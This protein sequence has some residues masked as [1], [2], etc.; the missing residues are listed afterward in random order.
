VTCDLPV[1]VIVCTRNRAH[2]LPDCLKSLSLQNCE[3]PF[4]VLVVDNGS[5]D[6]TPAVIQEWCLKDKRFRTTLEP[7]VGLSAAKNTG[8]RLARGQL[9]LF[10]DDDV[11][12]D[13]GWVRAYVTFFARGREDSI[14]AGGPIFPVP[15]DLED[16]PKWF[17]SCALADL[18]LLDYRDERPLGRREYVWGANMGIPACTFSRLGSWDEDV[19]RRG[20]A[21]GTFEDTEYQDRA[22]A[23]GG[24]TWFCPAATLRHRWPRAEITPSRILRTAF[25]RGRNEFWSEVL[26]RKEEGTFT[27]RHDYLRCLALLVSNLGAFTFWSLIFRSSWKQEHFVRAHKFAHASGSAMDLLRAGRESGRLSLAIGHAS[28]FVLDSVLHVLRTSEDR[29]G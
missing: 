22:R 28:M 2:Y 1:T 21:R 27:P 4:E 26:V 19:G 9:L 23:A 15:H 13:R 11:I 29:R 18:G 3:T 10:T 7:R 14:F 20:E 5:S 16:W 25:T 17:D 24:T 8:V 6:S 12:L